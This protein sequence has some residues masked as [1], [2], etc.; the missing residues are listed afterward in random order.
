[1]CYFGSQ[2][3]YNWDVVGPHSKILLENGQN[4]KLSK[5]KVVRIGSC[6]NCQNWKFPSWKLLSLYCQ[7]CQKWKLISL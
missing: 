2:D 4:W 3:S 1:M 6:Q 7:N 5:L